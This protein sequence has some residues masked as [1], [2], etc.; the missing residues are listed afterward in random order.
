MSECVILEQIKKCPHCDECPLIKSAKV[1]TPP[2][3]GTFTDK[4]DGRIY[5]TIKIGEQT[6]LAENLAFDYVGSKVYNNDFE[7]LAKFG[8][9]YNW[10]TAKL[11]VP[12]GWHLPSRDEWDKLLAYV[13]NESF[14]EAKDDLSGM[15]LKARSGW[16]NGGN[17]I[18]TFGFSALPAGYGNSSGEFFDMGEDATFWTSTENSSTNAYGRNMYYLSESVNRGNFNKTS[19]FSIRCLQD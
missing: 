16:K 1:E 3:Y 4:R 12:E 2:E 19:L 15:V 14:I 11:A 9:L 17:G 6:W 10:E 7:N 18:D 13:K 5:K 8:R